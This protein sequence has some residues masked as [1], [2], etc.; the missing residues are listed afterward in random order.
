MTVNGSEVGTKRAGKLSLISGRVLFYSALFVVFF[1]LQ[2]TVTT[3]W[4]SYSSA[5]LDAQYSQLSKQVLIKYDSLTKR[6]MVDGSKLSSYTFKDNV[7]Q[8]DINTSDYYIRENAT[9]LMLVRNWE[10][11]GALHSMRS[12]EDRF[13]RNYHYDWVFMNDVPFTDEFIEAT[14]AMASGNAYHVL[15][16]SSDW[17]TPEWIDK[18]LYEKRL[19]VMNQTNVLYGGSKSY[20]NM[21]RF[22]SGFFFRQEILSNYDYYFRVEPEVEYFCDFPYDPFKVMREGGKNN[23][24]VI[25]L[26]EYEETIPSLWEFVEEYIDIDDGRDIHMDSNSHKFITD[27]DIVGNNKAIYVSNNAYNMCHFWTN[28]E[29]GDLNFFRSDEYIR[30][31]EFLDSKGGFYYERWGDAPIHS[32]AASLLLDKDEV[33]HFDELGYKHDPYYTCPSAYYMFLKQRCQCNASSET[34]LDLHTL[35]CLRRWWKHGSGKNFMR[36]TTS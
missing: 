1:V 10:L 36:F 33:V 6:Y 29:I 23:G 21:C 25:T 5:I 4:S 26:R 16:P 13:N 3:L 22:N 31:F 15:I 20:R 28:F 19:E 14:S 8:E 24:F 11:A 32:I 30:F 7:L 18:D 12:L 34:N 27:D 35:S 17:D 9:L 2:Y